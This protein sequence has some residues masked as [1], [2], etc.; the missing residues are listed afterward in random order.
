MGGQACIVYG[1]AEF[2]RDT[3]LA[4]LAEPDNMRRL[5][6]ALT[7]LH[8][9]VIAVPPFDSEYL[10]RGH[11]VHFRCARS[12]VAGMRVDVM[13]RMR[14]VDAFAALWARRTTLTIPGGDERRGGEIDVLGLSD[15]VTAKKTQRDKD[16]PMIRRL[17]E[18]NWFAFRDEPTEARALF[19]LRELRAPA[20]L[21]ECVGTFAALAARVVAERPAIE[22]AMQGD[23]PAVERALS[24]EQDHER[25]LDRAYWAPLREEL[26][27]LRHTRRDRPHAQ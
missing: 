2:S 12:D 9:E 24:Q 14:G 16:W 23:I 15:L 26:E 10:A 21:V 27:Q 22:H 1:A 5:N 17:V 11:A 18:A 19:W 13:S 7:E 8:A 25:A 6:S 4:I 20:L 3:D